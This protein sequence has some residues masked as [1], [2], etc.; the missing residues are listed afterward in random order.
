MAGT[1]A[2]PIDTAIANASKA[3]LAVA[4]DDAQAR[5][6]L[7]E[8]QEALPLVVGVGITNVVAAGTRVTSSGRKRHDEILLL[9]AS[10]H[11]GAPVAFCATRGP[12][13]LPRRAFEGGAAGA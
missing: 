12:R 9:G 13:R 2:L 4:Q 7:A 8:T 3:D 5:L 1:L 10:L 6:E 11:A